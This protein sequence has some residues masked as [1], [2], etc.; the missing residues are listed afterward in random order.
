MDN[1]TRQGITQHTALSLVVS[2]NE[3]DVVWAWVAVV[4]TYWSTRYTFVLLTFLLV[5][6]PDWYRYITFTSQKTYCTFLRTLSLTNIVRVTFIYPAPPLHSLSFTVTLYSLF[7]FTGIFS[8][9][10]FGWSVWFCVLTNNLQLIQFS[11]LDIL[12]KRLIVAFSP[13]T[14]GELGSSM[15]D[16]EF[17]VCP[18]RC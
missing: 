3:S 1:R 17:D 2:T 18:D 4:G 6:C 16:P 7:F 14:T 13:V 12:Q 15:K 8:G 10:W 5:L 11:P 9:F